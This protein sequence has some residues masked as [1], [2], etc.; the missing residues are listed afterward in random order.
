[1]FRAIGC[2]KDAFLVENRVVNGFAIGVAERFALSVEDR[3]H[4][5]ERENGEVAIGCRIRVKLFTITVVGGEKYLSDRRV[6]ATKQKLW[7][8]V[9]SS[10]VVGIDG[11]K[12]VVVDFY[13]IFRNIDIGMRIFIP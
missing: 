6:V 13:L 9:Q 5:L 8:F 12:I 11:K 1:M 7:C 2:T 10:S 4:F 3:L